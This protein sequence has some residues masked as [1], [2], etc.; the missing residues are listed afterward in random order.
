MW[1]RLFTFYIKHVVGTKVS[2]PDALSRRGKAGEDS[3]DEDP[4]DL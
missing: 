3:K 1:I 2:G 4:D